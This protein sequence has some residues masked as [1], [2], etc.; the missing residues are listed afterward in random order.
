MS[1]EEI[2]EAYRRAIEVL[3][4]F[5]KTHLKLDEMISKNLHGITM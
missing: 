3:W 4:E 1:N 5:L 2:V